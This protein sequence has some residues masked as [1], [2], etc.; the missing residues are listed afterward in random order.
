MSRREQ[1][2]SWDA[3]LRRAT[4]VTAA[5]SL[6]RM[7]ENCWDDVAVRGILAVTLYA[8]HL[9]ESTPVDAIRWQQVLWQLHDDT[10]VSELA[11]SV[12]P[13][14]G[15]DL[16]RTAKPGDPVADCWRWL[17][18]TWDPH[19]PRN[20][21]P[22]KRE[23][24]HVHV[25]PDLQRLPHAPELRWGGMTRGIGRGLPDP[26]IEICT[27]WA[28]SIV[29]QTI[30][31]DSYGHHR[32]D[33]VAVLS[34]PHAGRRGYVVETGWHFDDATETVQGPAGYVIDLD[35]VTD[36]ARIDADAVTGSSDLRW[37]HR[38]AESLKDGPAQGPHAPL[39]PAKTSAEDLS[40]ILARSAD[41]SIVPESLR[42]KIAAAHSHHHLELER[43][44]RP[45]P[46]RVTWLVLHH[47]YQLTEHYADDQRAD[48]FELVVTRHLRDP[49][50]VHHI[51]LSEDDMPELIARFTAGG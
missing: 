12:L 34:G 19:A 13:L 32:H 15:H 3:A 14:A 20:P 9:R 48:L 29:Q 26:A 4:D 42:A 30:T 44:A 16:A 35:D 10:R 40:D 38:P 43:Q 6:G 22:D 39:P 24:L 5:H 31:T 21:V 37:P 2:A 33:R 36:T 11:S 25:P 27:D 17:T 18:R 7:D 41:P 28:A 47:W 45:A 46:G 50:P 49:H 51:A 23:T 8:L 1:H